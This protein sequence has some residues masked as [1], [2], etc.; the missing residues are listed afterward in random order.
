MQKCPLTVNLIHFIPNPNKT[1][2]VNVQHGRVELGNCPI[3]RF[4]ARFT[5]HEKDGGWREVGTC[6]Y[7][8]FENE[9]RL[10]LTWRKVCYA[11]GNIIFCINKHRYN[12]TIQRWLEGSSAY[13]CKMGIG[14]VVGALNSWL[15]G[16]IWAQ[17]YGQC[18]LFLPYR[19]EKYGGG[20]MMVGV[21]FT[22]LS[23]VLLHRYS[24]DAVIT[25]PTRAE[26]E[27][28]PSWK[29]TSVQ[30]YVFSIR[31]LHYGYKHIFTKEGRNL[32]Y[33]KVGLVWFPSFVRLV[34]KKQLQ[35]EQSLAKLVCSCSSVSSDQINRNDLN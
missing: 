10:P 28:E 8:P 35:A 24:R 11:G 9:S 16:R 22:V 5:A 17:M 12:W 27:D 19:E 30:L 13:V 23:K 6:V 2:V 3:E 33:R 21:G 18:S 29:A 31:Q 14:R 1:S 34:Y 25:R 7:L 26:P 32:P 4:L 20:G 15:V